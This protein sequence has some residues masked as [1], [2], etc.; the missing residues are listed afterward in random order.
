MHQARA[1][2]IKLILGQL[3]QHGYNTLL[4]FKRQVDDNFAGDRGLPGLALKVND[5]R[6]NWLV[7]VVPVQAQATVGRRKRLQHQAPQR[8]A[9]RHWHN[10]VKGILVAN[11]DGGD[12]TQT[13]S[14]GNGGLKIR[15][16]T[17]I[18]CKI[19]FTHIPD[20]ASDTV[21]QQCLDGL[22]SAILRHKGH[23]AT[24]Q[25]ALWQFAKGLKG[26][27]GIQPGDFNARVCGKGFGHG[28]GPRDMAITRALHAIEYFH[29]R[30]RINTVQNQSIAVNTTGAD[31][32]RKPT[33][34]WCCQ[35]TRPSACP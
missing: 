14:P 1:I 23:A 31:Q 21:A 9:W 27:A 11:A 2:K 19:Q 34:P 18:G 30:L 4:I 13:R 6:Q 35:S 28:V 33:R 25:T 5:G 32:T 22:E 15:D 24:P 17:V 12:T 16:D 3:P 10:M 29:Q 20:K 7:K 8:L 26:S